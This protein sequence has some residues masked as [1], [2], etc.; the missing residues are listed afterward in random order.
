MT[1]FGIGENW[2]HF[3]NK[4]GVVLSARQIFGDY[5]DISSAF[6]FDGKRMRLPD[7]TSDVLDFVS[8]V[9][10]NE[11]QLERKASIVIKNGLLTACVDKNRACVEKSAELIDRYKDL[12]MSFVI[13]V[14]FFK[15]ILEH[16]N[17]MIYDIKSGR[18]MFRSKNFK[19]CIRMMPEINT[20]EQAKEAVKASGEDDDMPF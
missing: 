19:H 15:N 17:T 4:E 13:N 18:A 8:P 3:K 9:I 1:E 16:T 11:Q 10:A 5:M 20:P 12:D 2:L 14:D 7:N 6:E